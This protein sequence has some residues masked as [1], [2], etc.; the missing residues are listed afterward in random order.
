V[1]QDEP[2]RCAKRQN[3]ARGEEQ[4]DMTKA[5]LECPS[6]TSPLRCT[7]GRYGGR[8]G[9]EFGD[10]AAAA[11]GRRYPGYPGLLVTGRGP[12]YSEVAPMVHDRAPVEG[13]QSVWAG[14]ARNRDA[15]K[16]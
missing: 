15:P 13:P 5:M 4:D 12:L 7:G 6:G 10:G 3:G 1:F 14:N 9:T 8:Y 11:A 16:M 2:N